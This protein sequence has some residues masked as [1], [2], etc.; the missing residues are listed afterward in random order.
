[1]L[2][3]LLGALNDSDFA[4][5]MEGY[6]L[7]DG[8]PPEVLSLARALVAWGAPLRDAA[9]A[10]LGEGRSALG[11]L[12]LRWLPLNSTL[13]DHVASL[14]QRPAAYL[15]ASARAA[16]ERGALLLAAMN[17]PALPPVPARPCEFVR[18]GAHGAR[19]I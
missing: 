14:L 9:I 19:V 4:A 5:F 17:P 16:A 8:A 1:D 7:L 2:E 3:G 15:G 13:L 11:S 18:L 6:L 10:S 12:L